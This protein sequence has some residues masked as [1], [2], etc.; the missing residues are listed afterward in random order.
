MPVAVMVMM[1]V[2]QVKI[3]QLLLKFVIASHDCIRFCHATGSGLNKMSSGA[4]GFNSGSAG[5]AFGFGSSNT[6]GAFNADSLIDCR[7][8]YHLFCAQVVALVTTRA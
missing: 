2:S 4:F 1:L 3:L 7:L 8:Y 6:G 5:G